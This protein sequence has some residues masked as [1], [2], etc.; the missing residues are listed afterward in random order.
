M[1]PGE[2]IC[3]C[4]VMNYNARTKCRDCGKNKSDIVKLRNKETRIEK[5]EKDDDWYCPRDDCFEKNV[6]S[7]NV[8]GRCNTQK[9][10][11]LLKK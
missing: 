1:N 9:P 7:K 10:V 6:A 11:S 3:E 4:E 5:L 2:W 8:C